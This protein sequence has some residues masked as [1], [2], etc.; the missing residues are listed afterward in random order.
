MA[1]VLENAIVET[2]RKASIYLPPDVKEALKMAYER[3]ESEAAKAQL[4]AILTNVELAEKLE[5]PI[6]QDT[7]IMIFYVKVGHNFPVPGVIKEALI[8]ATRRATQEIP[9]RPNTVDPFTGENPGD[10]TGRLIPYVHWELVPGDE[11]EITVVPKGGGSEYPSVYRM[12]PPG[13]GLEGLKETVVDA[14]LNAGAM[15]CPPTIVGV[16]VGGGAD[17]AVTLAKKAAT[18]RRIGSRNPDP[19]V[20]KLEEE[21]YEA[22]N[23]LGIGPMGVGGKTTVLAVNIE[24]AHRHPA[25]YP[26][27]V[28]FQCWAARRAT[29][30]M[31]AD[32]SYEILQ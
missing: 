8:R 32:G 30:R 1:D 25:N 10:N 29:L 11:L 26:V 15:P 2:I 23:E 12:V 24:W 6:C 4:K 17:I 5:R 9:L 21:L 28:V 18:L 3:E 27:A 13:R 16:G 31:K 20:A 19:Q 14:V 22:V 7:G